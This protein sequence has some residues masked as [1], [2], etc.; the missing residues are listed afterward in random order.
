MIR[1][2]LLGMGQLLVEGGKIDEN[3]NRATDMIARA[4]SAGCRIVVLPECLDSGW[5]HP[6]AVELAEPV[7]GPT[8]D[9]LAASAAEHNIYVVA[10]IT[11]RAGQKVYNTAVLLSPAGGLLLVHRKINVLGIAQDIYSIGDRLGVAETELGTIGVSICADNFPNS[12][13]FA[14]SMARMGAR[15]I[16]SPSAWAVDA[17]ATDESEPYGAMWREAYAEVA[18]LYD[19]TVAGVS[20]VGPITGGPWE[21]RK[22]IGKSVAVGPEGEVIAQGSY[23]ISA[24]EL[25]TTQV[26]L[27]EAPARG[28]SLCGLLCERGYEGP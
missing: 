7:P 8:S 21:G 1:S 20:N 3:L 17:D 11:E 24:E 25:V 6:S 4:S 27:R 28:T 5:T 22:C 18:K 15:L 26:T 12:L 10:G 2:F 19:L 14:H 16:L 13:V 9:V 23:G